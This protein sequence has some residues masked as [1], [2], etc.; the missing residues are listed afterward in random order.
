MKFDD[1]LWTQ[2]DWVI[3]IFDFFFHGTDFNLVENF[4]SIFES[5]FKRE[6][7]FKAMRTR[8]YR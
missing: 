8:S 6:N 4:T 2:R 7:F 3:E 1:F 5:I